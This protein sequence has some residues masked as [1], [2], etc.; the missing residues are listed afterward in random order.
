M[1]VLLAALAVAV[2]TH[3]ECLSASCVERV[4][5]KRCDQKH[6]TS[7]I[8][9]AALRWNVSYRK[10]RNRAW[11]ESRFNPYARNANS[12]ASGLFQ[13]LY[14]STWN[15]TRYARHSVFSAKYS[16]LA[17]AEL[18]HVGRGNEWSCTG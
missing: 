6:V 1:T 11:C 9:R 2:P 17:A 13:F 14:P 3:H 5:A 16:S 18:E 15:T 12:T 10:L 8:H 7:C 4:A